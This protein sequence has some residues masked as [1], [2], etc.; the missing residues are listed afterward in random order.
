MMSPELHIK[1]KLIGVIEVRF[2]LVNRTGLLIRSPLAKA[3]I[4]G[5][6][7]Q[8]MFIVKNYGKIIKDK[9]VYEIGEIEVPYI[10]GSSLKGRIRSLLEIYEGAPLY[11]SDN[12]IFI[13]VRDIAKNWC[14][15]LEHSLDNLFGSPSVDLSK[16]IKENKELTNE[17]LEKYAPTR[18]IVEDLYP[19]EDYVVKLADK[20]MLTKEAFI[21]EKTENTID[22]ITSAA[23][24]RTILR[25]KPDV[26]FKGNFKMLL[27][28]V[29]QKLGKIKEYIELL[30]TGMKLLEDTYLGGSGSR[31]YGR[32]KFKNISIILKKPEY[33][34]TGSEEYIIDILEKLKIDR[35]DSIELL[36]SRKDE[37]VNE[38]LNE[39]KG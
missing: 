18:L 29:D 4:G 32:V 25:V 34:K 7:I 26:E 3:T 6:D 24:P 9:Q 23:N 5:A 16:I 13:H 15:D 31:G 17:I 30:L 19:S 39:I 2:K 33:Y 11:S 27:Y 14:T 22:R 36:L 28:D 21:E 35:T 20:G 10:P 12:E 1:R 37:I 38:I 8:P